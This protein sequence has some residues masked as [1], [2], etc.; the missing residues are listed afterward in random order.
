M[1]DYLLR[2]AQE[3]EQFARTT[4]ND[5]EKAMLLEKARFFRSQAQLELRQRRSVN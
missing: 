3:A 5:A 4:S 1:V 2:K